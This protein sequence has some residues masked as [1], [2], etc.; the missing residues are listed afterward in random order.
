MAL[1]SSERKGETTFWT[2]SPDVLGSSGSSLARLGVQH[3][4]QFLG[5]S[6][7]V[8]SAGVAPSRVGASLGAYKTAE[9]LPA[10]KRVKKR[11]GPDGTSLD[12]VSQSSATSCD[13]RVDNTGRALRSCWGLLGHKKIQCLPKRYRHECYRV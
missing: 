7:S 12:R 5:L 13:I 6:E 10:Q 4:I 9:S 1:K 11:K 3:V 2:L 8:E